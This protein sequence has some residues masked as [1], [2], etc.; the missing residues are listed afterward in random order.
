MCL[1][2]EFE[3]QQQLLIKQHRSLNL[4][5]LQ[6]ILTKLKDL[7]KIVVQISCPQERLQDLL[8]LQKLSGWGYELSIT[9]EAGKVTYLNAHPEAV[10]FCKKKMPGEIH[11]QPMTMLLLVGN[12]HSQN[13]QL[14]KFIL[15]SSRT[16]K[17]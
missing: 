10:K 3:C 8:S 9:T 13:I 12:H 6:Q 1:K 17:K 5:V 2:A 15:L 4:A 7:K 14:M 11:R 16:R